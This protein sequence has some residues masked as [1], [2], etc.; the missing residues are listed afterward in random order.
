M[1]QTYG[2]CRLFWSG[3]ALWAFLDCIILQPYITKTPGTVVRVVMTSCLRCIVYGLF[4]FPIIFTECTSQRL[5]IF[6]H[7]RWDRRNGLSMSIYALTAQATSEFLGRATPFVWWLEQTLS[8]W[9]GA[10]MEGYQNSFKQIFLSQEILQR[11]VH[12]KLKPFAFTCATQWQR[13]PLISSLEERATA[14]RQ[15]W[16]NLATNPPRVLTVSYILHLTCQGVK[17]TGASLLVGVNSHQRV[18]RCEK[19]TSPTREPQWAPESPL[20]LPQ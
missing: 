16:Q 3:K 4:L 2:K 9:R 19:M 18:T 7:D 15:N 11:A 13:T 20:E 10:G 12:I 1:H 5:S 6:W 8:L 14:Q 17:D